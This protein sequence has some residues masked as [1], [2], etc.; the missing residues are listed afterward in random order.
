MQLTMQFAPSTRRQ[1]LVALCDADREFLASTPIEEIP[2]SLLIETRCQRIGCSRN[3]MLAMRSYDRA[4][5]LAEERAILASQDWEF[6]PAYRPN[7][8]LIDAIATRETKERMAAFQE[9]LKTCNSPKHTA[10]RS[11]KSGAVV[12][13]S[14]RRAK[15]A[16]GGTAR[17]VADQ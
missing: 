4:R 6:I 15:P 3:E 13:A 17:T 12:S 9:Y 16:A 14:R 8:A 11:G 7:W 2:E 1:P 5:E 10:E